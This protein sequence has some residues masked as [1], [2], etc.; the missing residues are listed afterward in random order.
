MEHEFSATSQASHDDTLAHA[1]CQAVA[2]STGAIAAMAGLRSHIDDRAVLAAIGPAPTA[3]LPRREQSQRAR[4]IGFLAL[5]PPDGTCAKDAETRTLAAWHTALPVSP[6]SDLEAHDIAN[7]IAIA[8][9]VRELPNR[10]RWLAS[11][12][13]L[14]QSVGKSQGTKR[15]PTATADSL[16]DYRLAEAHRDLFYDPVSRACALTLWRGAHPDK[17]ALTVI[18]SLPP[19]TRRAG[20]ASLPFAIGC[21]LDDA[22]VLEADELTSVLVTHGQDLPWGKIAEPV[23]SALRKRG[24]AGGKATVKEIQPLIMGKSLWPPADCAIVRTVLSDRDMW[25]LLELQSP[26]SEGKACAVKLLSTT[27]PC[28]GTITAAEELRRTITAIERSENEQGKIIRLSGL[29]RG[30][31]GAELGA[32]GTSPSAPLAEHISRTNGLISTRTANAEQGAYTLFQKTMATLNANGPCHDTQ[33]RALN[34]LHL[35]GML[36]RQSRVPDAVKASVDQADFSSI[37][38]P[39]VADHLANTATLRG[40]YR[41]APHL[42][43]HTTLARHICPNRPQQKHNLTDRALLK[44]ILI[45]KCNYPVRA[46]DDVTSFVAIAESKLALKWLAKQ[47][48]AF[49]QTYAIGC[50]A[51]YADTEFKAE[52]MR[53]VSECG[54]QHSDSTH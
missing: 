29:A 36:P 43:T 16:L 12:T 42:I 2:E 21:L 28:D 19:L 48:S 8:G 5:A 18:A 37:S 51:K 17:P 44:E 25:D 31:S 47:T 53:V 34:L 4:L 10:E 38:P 46:P 6:Y 15:L 27:S 26:N 13:Q 49:R 30:L 40:A 41:V 22:G 24:L 35:V 7:T 14:G 33:E 50:M 52:L 3:P 9:L 45:T 32:T 54:D 1:I 20:L 39:R 23:M 11:I